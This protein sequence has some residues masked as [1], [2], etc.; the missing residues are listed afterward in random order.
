MG[1]T[2]EENLAYQ[3]RDVAQILCEQ[4]KDKRQVEMGPIVGRV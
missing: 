1:L 4:W 3:L 2:L